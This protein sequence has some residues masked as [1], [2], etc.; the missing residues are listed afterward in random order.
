MS[1]T[2]DLEY[3]RRGVGAF[4]GCGRFLA[5]NFADT[6]DIVCDATANVCGECM[7]K[8]RRARFV[9]M[10]TADE[11]LAVIEAAC[12]L[13][14]TGDPD[15]AFDAVQAYEDVQRAADAYIAAVRAHRERAGE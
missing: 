4:D 13:V 6:D 7:E 3:M 10:G 9:H 5:R 2:D 15:E 1:D 11:A 14:H 12:A 8:R